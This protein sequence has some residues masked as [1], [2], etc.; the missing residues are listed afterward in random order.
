MSLRDTFRTIR[1]IDEVVKNLNGNVA[2]LERICGG[3]DAD[4]TI[5]LGIGG[6]G[7]HIRFS[8]KCIQQKADEVRAACQVATQDEMEELFRHGTEPVPASEC[9]DFR[10]QEDSA[11]DREHS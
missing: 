7:E 6:H 4:S 9:Q 2:T 10:E 3:F 5:R 11:N 8:A 1:E